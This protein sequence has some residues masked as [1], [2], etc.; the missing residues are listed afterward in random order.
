MRAWDN[1]DIFTLDGQLPDGRL[2]CAIA[3]AHVG[4]ACPSCQS[5]RD[6]RQ[7][8]GRQKTHF[9]SRLKRI[10]PVQSSLPKIF[11]FA[12]PEIEVS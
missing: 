7:N 3:G 5:M 8:H 2:T 9:A 4:L 11:L 6:Y 1:L 12:F 10:T